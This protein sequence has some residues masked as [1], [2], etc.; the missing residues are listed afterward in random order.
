MP[1]PTLGS[2]AL[3]PPTPSESGRLVEGFL[4]SLPKMLPVVPWWARYMDN[5]C[6]DYDGWKARKTK[7]EADAQARK[8]EIADLLGGVRGT[9]ASAHPL[10]GFENGSRR[11]RTD[12]PMD[13]SFLTLPETQPWH[14]FPIPRLPGPIEELGERLLGPREAWSDEIWRFVWKEVQKIRIR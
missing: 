11:G 8:E 3:P 13:S 9:D 5:W 4:G 2:T 10:G 6:L 7:M 14:R 1:P 12:Y